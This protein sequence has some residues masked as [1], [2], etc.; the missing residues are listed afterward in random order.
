MKRELY[1]QL[2]EQETIHWWFV[3]R[4][5]IITKV[6][7]KI[8]KHTKN[9]PHIL[10]IGCGTGGN[11]ELLARFGQLTALELDKEAALLSRDKNICAVIEGSLPNNIPLNRVYDLI[12]MFDVLEH[13]DDDLGSLLTIKKVL[14]PNGDLILTVPA[15]MFLWSDHDNVNHHKRRYTKKTILTIL[16]KAGYNV[17]YVTYFNTFLFPVVALIRLLSKLKKNKSGSDFSKQTPK[18]VNQALTILFSVGQIFFPTLTF[19]FGVSLL[20]VAKPQ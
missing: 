16:N 6:L 9:K 18:I 15:F 17:K 12:A 13:I 14:H 3:A 4:R 11:L 5:A 19:P 2:H 10:E 20:I 1:Y 8:L 7:A